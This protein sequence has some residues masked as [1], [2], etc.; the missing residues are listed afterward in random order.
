MKQPVVVTSVSTISSGGACLL[1]A[2]VLALA[3]CAHLHGGPGQEP[4]AASQDSQTARALAACLDRVW[5][6]QPAVCHVRLDAQVEYGDKKFPLSCF[7]QL[8]A[9]ARSARVVG[10]TDMGLK[11]FDLSVTERDT[12]THAMAPNVRKPEELAQIVAGLTRRV[13]L[14]GFP[15]TSAPATRKNELLRVTGARGVVFTFDLATSTLFKVECEAEGWRV[16]YHEYPAAQEPGQPL[17]PRRIRYEDLKRGFSAQF[18][19]HKV[20]RR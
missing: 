8:D 1:L 2:M 7:M 6:A 10:M 3:S 16:S 12:R 9:A 20:T 17:A 5:L 18:L 13:F 11:L 14:Q 15:A 19:L 4:P